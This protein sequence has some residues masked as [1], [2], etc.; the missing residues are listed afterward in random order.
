MKSLIT[1]AAGFVGRYLAQELEISGYE[2]IAAKLPFENI[3]FKCSAVYDLDITKPADI[4]NILESVKP[5]VIF[6]L[7]AQSSVAVSWKSPHTTMEVNVCGVVNLLEAV[8]DVCPSACVLLV[9]S[10]EEYGL[11]GEEN[12]AINEDIYVKPCNIYAVSRAT[13]NMLGRVYA[14]SYNMN[15]MMTRSFNHIGVGQA[16]SFVISDFCR[17]VAEIEREIKLPEMYVGNIK[18][19]RDFSD[20]RDVVKA[21]RIITEKGTKGCTY[22]VGSGKLITIENVLETIIGFASKDVA[23]KIDPGKYRP[24]DTPPLKADTTLLKALGW[25]TE[26]SI[27]QSLHDMYIHWYNSI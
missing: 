16:S 2:V 5:D 23:V 8:R 11:A 9:G 25:K 7:A 24:S 26:Y 12:T 18:T 22:N 3:D 17:Q 1:G 6:H 14:D 15:V 21:Y 10:S 13:Q 27:E 20:V 4:V 19:S